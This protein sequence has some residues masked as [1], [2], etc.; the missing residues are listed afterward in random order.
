MTVLIFCKVFETVLFLIG[1][2][3]STSSEA[4]TNFDLVTPQLNQTDKPLKII[5]SKGFSTN[6]MEE[7]KEIPHVVIQSLKEYTKGLEN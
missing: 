5:M 2:T 4:Q 7:G 6:T 1:L 3:A